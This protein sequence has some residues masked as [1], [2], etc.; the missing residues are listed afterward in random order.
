MDF[1]HLNGQVVTERR[2]PQPVVRLLNAWERE[3]LRVLRVEGRYPTLTEQ[4][5]F[6]GEAPSLP[7]S[8]PP[9]LPPSAPSSPLAS[10]PV[11]PP[12]GWSDDLRPPESLLADE[13]LDASETLD[14]NA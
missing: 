9:S 14:A 1:Y 11:T 3:C 6:L 13:T 12:P 8:P 5:A 4:R 10:R 7:P 2:P